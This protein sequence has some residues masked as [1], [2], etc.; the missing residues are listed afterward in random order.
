MSLPRSGEAP[1]APQPAKAAEFVGYQLWRDDDGELRVT[2]FQA[3]RMVELAPD[4][5]TAKQAP[6]F[7]DMDHNPVPDP[8]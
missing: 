6:G 5:E 7:Y 4:E 2:A 3:G 1:A 8:V